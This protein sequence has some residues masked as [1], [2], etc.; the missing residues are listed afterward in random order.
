MTAGRFVQIAER[1][2]L[3]DA[4]L[5]RIGVNSDSTFVSLGRIAGRGRQPV[6]STLT[7]SKSKVIDVRSAE[8]IASFVETD[9][10]FVM[11]CVI[12]DVI[13]VTLDEDNRRH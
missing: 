1:F 4:R 2:V 12:F 6:N 3:T 8:T 10:T 7:E 11:T 13:V 9:A 5:A